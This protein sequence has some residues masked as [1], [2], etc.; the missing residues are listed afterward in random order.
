MS[1]LSLRPTGLALFAAA[2]LAGS[3]AASAQTQLRIGLQDDPDVLDPH[4]ARTYV[5]RL[6]FTA[7]CDKLV[8][9]TPDLKIVPQLATEWKWSD[10]GLTL[11][12]KLKSGVTFH[13]GT[14][15]DAEAVKFNLDR[16]RSLP[17]SMRKSEVAS[18]ESVTA[19]DPGTVAIKVKTPDATLLAQFADRSGMMLSPKASA[20]GDVAANPVCSGP[21]KF[22][23]RVQNDRIT[24]ERYAEHWNKAAYHFDRIV[25]V[26]IPDT[27]VRFAN[28]RSG[29]LDLIERMAASDVKGAKGDAKISV[30][31][32]PGLGY[33]GIDFNVG[34]GERAKTPSG[35]DARVRQAF[36]AAIDRAVINEAVF[37]GLYPPGAQPFPPTSPYHVKQDVPARDVEKAKALL[38]EAGVTPPLKLELKVANNPVSQQVAQVVQAMTAEAGFDVSLLAT[39]Y[40]TLLKEQQV[41]NFQV[42]MRAWS[43]RIDPDGNIHQFLSCKGNLNDMKY[44]NPEVD[45][46]LN[47][48][49]Q[50]TDETKRREMYTAVIGII[51]KDWP[52]VYLYFEPRI[53]AMTKKLQGF[54]AHPDGM[55][56]F[57]GVKLGG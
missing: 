17:E 7:L 41:G 15:F 12:M 19:V 9:A 50:V 23:S 44:C 2:L 45:K 16:A 8:D 5:S 4:R 31:A 51:Q 40:A 32:T 56:R 18:I 55:I 54:T 52:T 28:L 20:S 38:K 6:V 43:G 1:R 24:V 26:T 14:P 48:A 10:D 25:F 35:Q 47:E 46:L 13:D 37:E 42:G 30:V 29:D 34:N 21:Y 22:V 57:A 33:M 49:R 53:F 3:T 39:E 27:T 11:T 36:S